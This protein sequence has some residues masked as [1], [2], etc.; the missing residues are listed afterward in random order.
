MTSERTANDERVKLYW[1][2]LGSCS[3]NDGGCAES[4]AGLDLEPGEL[5]RVFVR[6]QGDR[7]LNLC[8]GAPDRSFVGFAACTLA[9][10]QFP[11]A[12]KKRSRFTWE[13][14][15]MQARLQS[16]ILL[17]GTATGALADD[18]KMP[19]NASQLN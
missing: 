14:W 6:K 17:L 18:M 10:T 16:L 7:H 15:T 5:K 13:R 1:E 4:K 11:T 19:V 8:I 12:Q 9:S 3:V 2:L